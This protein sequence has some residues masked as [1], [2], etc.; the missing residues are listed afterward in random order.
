M[1]RQRELDRRIGRDGR[2]LLAEE[3]V[4]LSSLEE[5]E[6]ARLHLLRELALMLLD[7]FVDVFYRT[8][9]LN[10]LSRRLLAD[11]FHTLDVVG[12]IA[13]QRLVVDD[14]LGAET[15]PLVHP[16]AVVED[17]VVDTLLERKDGDRAIDELQ[18]IHIA[19]RD[20]NLDVLAPAGL[21]DQRTDHVVGLETRRAQDRDA[22]CREHFRR[23]LQLGDEFG[24]SLRARALVVLVRLVPMRLSRQIARRDDVIGLEL[25]G[26]LQEHRGETI[27]GTGRLA[28]ARREIRQR[29]VRPVDERVRIDEDEAL[30][31]RGFHR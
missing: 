30:L 27:Q 10:K 20:D 19:R 12:W 29:V 26:K 23:L 25:L 13:A 16:V 14:V 9:L 28:L 24:I 11:A 31:R 8:E 18:R 15:V 7:R 2:E 17:G 4:V 22:E 6:D 21:C 3:C 1:I 5:L